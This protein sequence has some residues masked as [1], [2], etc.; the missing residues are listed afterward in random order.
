MR[1]VRAVSVAVILSIP[2]SLLGAPA[3]APPIRCD[4]FKSALNKSIGKFDDLL[5]QPSFKPDRVFPEEFQQ[6]SIPS[7]SI[8]LRCDKGVF[9][10]Y[11]T[12]LMAGD[13][14]SIV[15]WLLWTQASL[16]AANE[17]IS[18]GAAL[19]KMK[20]LQSGAV[21]E[22]QRELIRSGMKMGCAR[23]LEGRY[24][25]RYTVQPG[26]LSM[27]MSPRGEEMEICKLVR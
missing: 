25:V 17:R 24:E 7:I 10:S 6:A 9:Q 8:N 22:S 11:E 1:V 26:Y 23:V 21:Q 20:V 16:G 13:A 18:K 3:T 15:R 14:A 12:G 19:G 4:E 5:P 27:A 2:G